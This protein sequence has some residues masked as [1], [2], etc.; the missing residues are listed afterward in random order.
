MEGSVV[1]ASAAPRRWVDAADADFLR[2]FVRSI[3]GLLD[4][5]AAA[6]TLE[7]LAVQEREGT[8]GGVL[9]I[10][11][12]YGRYFALLV[13][14]AL[15]TDDPIV[16]LDT[17]EVVDRR[18]VQHMLEPLVTPGGVSYLERASRDVTAGDLRAVLGTGARFI[19]IDGSHAADDVYHDLGLAA[20]VLAPDGIVAMDDF[21]CPVTPGVGEGAH[22]F[23]AQARDLLAPF[24]YTANKLFL[25]RPAANLKYRSAFEAAVRGDETDQRSANFRVLI[26]EWRPLVELSLWGSPMLVVP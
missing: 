1:S 13:R 19:S 2:E 22:R 21:L 20:E 26:D 24:A 4:H 7:L 12:F 3:P 16:A 17:F 18:L 10:G 15:R 6:R 14:S 11:I 9:E 5:Y 25:S 8:R 23:F